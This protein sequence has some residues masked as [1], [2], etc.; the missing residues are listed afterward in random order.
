M[1][2]YG[3]YDCCEILL[4]F[5]LDSEVKVVVQYCDGKVHPAGIVMCCVCYPKRLSR[6]DFLLIPWR[7]KRNLPAYVRVGA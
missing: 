6:Y 4:R 5:L 2:R 7:E 3:L 1:C